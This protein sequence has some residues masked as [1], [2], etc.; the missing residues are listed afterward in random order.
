MRKFRKCFA[1]LLVWCMVMQCIMTDTTRLVHA[2]MSIKEFTQDNCL[3]RVEKQ[4]EWDNGY[5]A[6][7]TIT[8][9]SPSAINN[10]KIEID[11]GQGMIQNVWNGSIKQK[12]GKITFYALDYNRTIPIGETVS[13]GYEM[14]GQSFE[15]LSSMLFNENTKSELQV[16]QYVVTYKITSQ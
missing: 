1:L 7:V 15:E 16:E 4:A 8:N 5:I 3:I 14:S 12:N 9:T 6:N 2:Q 13:I 10:W 11:A